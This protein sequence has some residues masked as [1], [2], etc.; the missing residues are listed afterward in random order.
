MIHLPNLPLALLGC[1]FQNTFRVLT[2]L[3]QLSMM[4]SFLHLTLLLVLV[5]SLELL[6]L[7]L[8]IMQKLLPTKYISSI[9]SSQQ[10]YL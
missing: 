2:I 6:L 5:R 10:F 3:D 8:M 9:V 4:R 1:S 7:I